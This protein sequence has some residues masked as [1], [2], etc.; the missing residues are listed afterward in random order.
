MNIKTTFILGLIAILNACDM[1]REM[2][3]VLS[4][5]QIDAQYTLVRGQCASLYNDL[6]AGYFTFG[7]GMEASAC[8]EADLINGGSVQVVNTGSWN[9]FNN[10]DE[11]LSRYYT[12]IRRVNDF[13]NPTTDV[14]LDAYRLDPTS[15]SQTIYKERLAEIKNWRYEARFLRAFYYF[16]LIK[17]YGGVSIV[18]EPLTL[19]T[20]FSVLKR[21]TLEECIQ[22]IVEECDSVS[23]SGALPVSYNADNLGRATKGAAMALKSRVLL[24]AASDLYN[25]SEW[26]E[27]YTYPELISLPA[28]DRKKRWEDAAKA[29]KDIIDLAEAGYVLEKD[30]TIIGKTFDSKEMIFL[31]RSTASNSFEITNFPVGLPVGNG[32]VNPTQNLVDAYEMKSDGSKFDWSNPSQAS[33]PYYNRDPRLS[34]SI[35]HNESLFNKTTLLEIY[36]GGEHG[37]GLANATSTGYYIRKFIDESLDLVQNRTSVHSWVFFRIAEIYLNYAEALNESDPGNSDILTYVNKTRQRTGVEMPLITETDQ[38]KVR[39]RIRN[40]RRVELAFEGHRLWDVRRWMTAADDLNTPVHGVDC[41]YKDYEFIYTKKKIE[42]RVFN[43]K[44]YFYP[45][46]Q[47]L[48]FTTNSQWVQNPIW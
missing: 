42:D 30:Y 20:D 18:K 17:R 5:E 41:V 26:T 3:D 23:Q 1:P 24:Y 45:I 7:N 40:E 27:G 43:K 22:F 35:L 4:K 46:P 39:E 21:N 14:N 44:M 15:G 19:E 32:S 2:V 37:K 31:R 29:A 28:G 9:Q 13:L 16:E 34:F 48:L 12:A 33:N 25:S 47:S 11:V 36:E 38:T 8:D 6:L 10:P